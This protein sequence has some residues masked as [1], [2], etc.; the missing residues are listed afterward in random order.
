[1]DLNALH[2]LLSPEG[3][4]V[5][6]NTAVQPLTPQTHLQIAAQ[7]RGQIAPELAQAVLETLL[8]RQKA[9]GKFSR[10]A[11]IRAGFR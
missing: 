3:Q 8:L 2:W 5:M 9:V 10:A 11:A 1:M 7:L 4:W 6:A